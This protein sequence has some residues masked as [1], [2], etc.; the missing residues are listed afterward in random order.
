MDMRRR[1]GCGGDMDRLHPQRMGHAEVAAEEYDNY[2]VELSSGTDFQSRGGRNI[3]FG[4]IDKLSY[5]AFN[6]GPI[7]VG[8][9]IRILE[10]ETLKR[11]L[12]L[13]KFLFKVC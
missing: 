2:I 10:R 11:A 3:F 9:W 5:Q 7:K 13:V 12:K 4:H 6:F 1:L 8:N